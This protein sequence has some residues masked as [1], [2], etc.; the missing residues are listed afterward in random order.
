MNSCRTRMVRFFVLFQTN[1]SAQLNCLVWFPC[2]QFSDWNYHLCLHRNPTWWLT[3]IFS[4]PFTTVCPVPGRWPKCDITEFNVTLP[5]PPAQSAQPSLWFSLRSYVVQMLDY[6]TM[7]TIT[8]SIK[9]G[10]L[11]RHDGESMMLNNTA[12]VISITWTCK[13]KA[14]RSLLIMAIKS[15]KQGGFCSYRTSFQHLTAVNKDRGLL[16]VTMTRRFLAMGPS[17]KLGN[18]CCKK[19]GEVPSFYSSVL[20]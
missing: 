13:G 20:L 12:T 5:I 16:L 6:F 15:S 10:D 2:T 9:I 7:P 19:L 8:W 14:S 17:I 11:V 18:T 4:F 1:H 3:F